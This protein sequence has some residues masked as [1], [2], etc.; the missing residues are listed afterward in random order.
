M[1]AASS[2]V[3]SRPR[4]RAPATFVYFRRPPAGTGSCR[5]DQAPVL[6]AIFIGAIMGPNEAKAMSAIGPNIK[7]LSYL[8]HPSD[9]GIES[10]DILYFGYHQCSCFSSDGGGDLRRGKFASLEIGGLSRRKHHGGGAPAD[11]FKSGINCIFGFLA[12]SEPAV[13][14]KAQSVGRGVPT[15]GRDGGNCIRRD[16]VW[17]VGPQLK[18]LDKD[19]SPIGNALR[20]V[21]LFRS[22]PLQAAHSDEQARKNHEPMTISQ[23][24]NR[25]SWFF[26]APR[27]AGTTLSSLWCYHYRWS[28]RYVPRGFL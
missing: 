4:N 17:R 8:R 25:P 2:G 13:K 6:G 19:K 21:G 18:P 22:E 28:C 7:A 26:F 10:I 9:I 23:Y 20:F 24:P 11:S 15:V 3:L 12:A 5:R 27:F 1:Y 16:L 14:S